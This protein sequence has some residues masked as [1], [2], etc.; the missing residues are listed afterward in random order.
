M[1]KGQVFVGPSGQ[2]LEA[3]LENANFPTAWIT[4]AALCYSSS[5]EKKA[6]AAVHCRRRLMTEIKHFKPKLVLALG[7]L[8]LQTIVPGHS[9]SMTKSRG[10]FILDGELNLPVLPTW[11]PAAVLRNPLVFRD[12]IDDVRKASGGPLSREPKKMH[13][14]ILQSS[15]QVRKFL[16]LRRSPIVA[17]DLETS[18]FDCFKDDILCAVM[19]FRTIKGNMGICVLPQHLINDRKLRL[20]LEDESIEWVGHGS[21]FDKLFLKAKGI[22]D[23]Y[24]RHDTLLM[25]YALDERRGTHNLKDLAS[26]TFNVPDWEA[27]IAQYLKR[28]RSDSYSNLPRQVL[29]RYSAYDGLYTYSLFEHLFAEITKPEHRE[30]L[31]VYE[32]FL[33]PGSDALVDMELRGVKVD[34]EMMSRLSEDYVNEMSR[35]ETEMQGIT[36]DVDFN[37][38]SPKQIAHWLYDEYGLN[39]GMGRTTNMHALRALEHRHPLAEKMLRYRQLHKLDRTYLEGWLKEVSEHDGRI[40]AYFNLHSTVSGRMACSRPNLQNLRYDLEDIVMSEEGKLLIEADYEQIELKMCALQSEDEWLIETYRKGGDLHT[41]RALQIFGP[42][43][44]KEQRVFCKRIHFGLI[45][46]RSARSLAQDSNLPG[47]DQREAERIVSD[48]F[49]RMPGVLAWR[50]AVQKLVR[51]RGYIRSLT[52]RHRRFPLITWSNEAEVMRQCINFK[53]QS[54]AS[55]AM[56]ASLIRLSKEYPAIDVILSIHDSLLAEM[57]EADAI[58][59]ARIMKRVMEETAAEMYGDV[60]PLTVGIKIGRRKG[61]LEEVQPEHTKTS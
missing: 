51:E 59:T 29:Y 6:A 40:H 11:H 17:L 32:R 25:H 44:T 3:A 18:G 24:F 45:Y 48:F 8:A 37:P 20:L 5:A 21:K 4:N 12:F 42:S 10:K 23:V 39:S 27:D 54:P 30:E 34:T 9:S 14:R 19:A 22:A 28:P 57:P 33:V 13:V 38:R 26:Y 52:R 60:V 16:L 47:V 2:L 55:D 53:C 7:N 43:F 1:R 41:E 15:Q 36:G 49:G 56:L 35:L 31:E 58:P 61:S 46:G 50:E